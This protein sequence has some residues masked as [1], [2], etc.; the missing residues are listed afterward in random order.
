[1]LCGIVRFISWVAQFLK[2]VTIKGVQTLLKAGGEAIKEGAMVKDVITST[3][4]PTLGAVLGATV[5]KVASKLIKMRNNQNDA[6]PPNPPIMLL[7]LIW[8]GQIKSGAVL[9]YERRH[10]NE[11][12]IYLTSYQVFFIF[13]MAI[14]GGDVT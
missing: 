4:K 5:D 8:L 10:L 7:S 3:L 14:I 11:A 13:K 12:S 1:M 6:P 2:P 9:L